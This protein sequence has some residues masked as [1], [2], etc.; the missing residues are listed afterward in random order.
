MPRFCGAELAEGSTRM[1][2]T[3]DDFDQADEEMLSYTVS[4]EALEVA[5]G[6]ERG[7]YTPSELDAE[8]LTLDASAHCRPRL[9]SPTRI[10]TRW[11]GLP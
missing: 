2:D 11:K 9:T 6:A 4:D 8:L 7:I 5:A 3:A 10:P 1:S